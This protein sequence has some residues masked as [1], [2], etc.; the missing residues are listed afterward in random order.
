MEL[1]LHKY[2]PTTIWCDKQSA[3][4]L[5]KNPILHARTK[6]IKLHHHNI[7]EKTKAGE[8]DVAYIST[9]DQKPN[10]MTKPLGKIRNF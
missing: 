8:I 4:K 6:H 9:N 2:A 10:I 3:I 5:V 1:G 7:H